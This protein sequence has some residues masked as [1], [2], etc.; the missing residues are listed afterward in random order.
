LQ[1]KLL[2]VQN[3]AHPSLQIEELLHPVIRKEP[4]ISASAS[5]NEYAAGHQGLLSEKIGSS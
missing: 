4:T 2:V 5:N 3:I 1:H